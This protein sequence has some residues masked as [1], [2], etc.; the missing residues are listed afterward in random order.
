MNTCHFYIITNTGVISNIFTII[1]EHLS[2]L[3]RILKSVI[4]VV[5][6]NCY[7]GTS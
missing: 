5:T 1:Y 7:F 4:K 3:D 2:N 6:L